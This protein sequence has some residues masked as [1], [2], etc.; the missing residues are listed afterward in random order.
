MKHNVNYSRP[1][2]RALDLLHSDVTTL[3][4]Y[5]GFSHKHKI[6][7]LARLLEKQEKPIEGSQLTIYTVD[8]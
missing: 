6:N 4:K 2:E 5:V 7:Q 8:G 3:S 1:P